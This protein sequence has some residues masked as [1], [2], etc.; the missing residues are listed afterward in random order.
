[1]EFQ[2]LRVV[3]GG[4]QQVRQGAGLLRRGV[5]Q[6][7]GEVALGVSINKKNRFFCGGKSGSQIQHSGGF[8]TSSLK[9]TGSKNVAHSAP[10]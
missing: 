4:Q 3:D 1:M 8:S 7:G 6:G 2:I 10:P 9:I 5:A